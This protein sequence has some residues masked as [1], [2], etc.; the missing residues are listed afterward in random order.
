[1]SPAFISMETYVV[2]GT[3]CSWLRRS[4][5]SPIAWPA[6][7]P[8]KAPDVVFSCSVKS[9]F[10]LQGHFPSQ[11]KQTNLVTPGL[12]ADLLKETPGVSPAWP[13]ALTC[14]QLILSVAWELRARC[15]PR[16][17]CSGFLYK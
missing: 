6:L 1:M 15:I 3:Q 2:G 4:Q 8:A 5:T 16:F 7:P 10:Q 9:A 13:S 17:Y 14:R 12:Q 11:E